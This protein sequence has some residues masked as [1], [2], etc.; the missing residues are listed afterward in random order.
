MTAAPPSAPPAGA[1]PTVPAGAPVAGV[2]APRA[3]LVGGL[4]D[5][6]DG[7]LAA[8]RALRAARATNDVVGLAIPLDGDPTD[9]GAVVSARGAPAKSRF[10]LVRFLLTVVDPHRPVGQPDGWARGRTGILAKVILDD[11]TRWLVGVST[12]RVP[13][14]DGGPGVWVLGRPNHAAAVNGVR[15]A[16]AEGAIGAVASLGVP[17]SLAATYAERLAGGQSVL[18]TCETD[19][20]RTRRDAKI[21][22]RNGAHDTFEHPLPLDYG[23]RPT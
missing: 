1:A 14:P 19:A 3:I 6:P 5:G 15:A 18:T 4:F 7:V 12:F 21:L 10:D 16:A 13:G 23:V 22:K 9:P 20:G 2:L 17:A 11:L 8:L